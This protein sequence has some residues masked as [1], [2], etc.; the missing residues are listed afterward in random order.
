MAQVGREVATAPLAAPVQDRAPAARLEQWAVVV[1][2]GRAVV[3]ARAGRV[4][5][6]GPAARGHG[7]PAV[8]RDVGMRTNPLVVAVPE[9]LDV[10]PGAANVGRV[11][12]VTVRREVRARAMAGLAV[13]SGPVGRTDRGRVL[14]G[15]VLVGRTDRGRVLHGRVRPEPGAH[16]VPRALAT[17]VATT[18]A[19]AVAA[20]LGTGG[21][22]AG[23][24]LVV[25]GLVLGLVVL[26]RVGLPTGVAMIVVRDL[27]P[28][29]GLSEPRGGPNRH[30]LRRNFAIP[31]RP[32]QAKA[33]RARHHRCASCG[34]RVAR[35]RRRPGGATRI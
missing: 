18:T 12:R 3:P 26:A 1:R 31:A 29:V 24:G 30:R 5:Q 17:P 28:K 2:T 10:R 16:P 21:P 7:R 32:D 19:G 23:P 33:D 11:A 4:A 34:A 8:F 15:R 25:L 14:H 27:D 22:G 9:R 13:A 20:A 35:R 6:V